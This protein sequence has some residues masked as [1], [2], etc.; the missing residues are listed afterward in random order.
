M[1]AYMIFEVNV[2]DG[3]WRKEYAPKTAELVQKH[4]GRYLAAGPAEKVEG[5][6]ALPSVVVV[7]EFPSVEA[8]KAWHADADYQPMIKLRNTGS[9]AEALLVK[10]VE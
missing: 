3:S 10:G 2:T 6:R 8:A 5:S 4:G 1:A 7:L 9:T